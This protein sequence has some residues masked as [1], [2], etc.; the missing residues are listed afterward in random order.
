MG[1][2]MKEMIKNILIITV[3]LLSVSYTVKAQNHK[4]FEKT[5]S[6]SS[7]GSVSIN[8]YKGSVSVEAWDK[9]EVYVYAEMVADDNWNCTSPKDQ[10]NEVEID[11]SNSKNYVRIKSD[12]MRKNSSGCNTLAL[13]NYKIKMP[14]TAEL[15]IEDYKSDIAVDGINNYVD[16]NCY[17]GKIKLANISDRIDLETYKGN[18][19]V[20]FKNLKGRCK[21]DTYKGDIEISLPK[22]SKFSV[23]VD[24]EKKGDFD[25]DFDISKKNNHGQHKEYNFTGDVN[26]GGPYLNLSSYRGSI[27]II[28]K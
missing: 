10:L 17:K 19:Q 18:A 27:R 22:D 20:S 15:E 14:R 16:I 8:T 1:N 11:V 9:A 21:F 23:D 12:Y 3:V 26:G 6:I 25:C 5:Y 2:E 13:V 28:S 4:E 7:T 24:I